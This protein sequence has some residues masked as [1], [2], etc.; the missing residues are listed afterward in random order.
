MPDYATPFAFT[1]TVKKALVDVTEE[2]I[3]GKAGTKKIYL[4]DQ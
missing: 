1:G 2:P 4:V 3:E